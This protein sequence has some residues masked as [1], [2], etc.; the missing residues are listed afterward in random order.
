MAIIN[1]DIE[2]N[3]EIKKDEDVQKAQLRANNSEIKATTNEEIRKTN[4]Y[5]LNKN[6]LE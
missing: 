1:F 4:I 5:A 3:K 2:I 6:H